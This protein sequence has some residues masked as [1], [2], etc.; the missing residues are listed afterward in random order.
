M[1]HVNG[2]DVKHLFHGSFWR[3]SI[4]NVLSVIIFV[5]TFLFAFGK[6]AER[7][8]RMSEW[9]SQANNRIERMDTNGTNF[10][11]TN[12]ALEQQIISSHENRI[13]KMEELFGR[14]NVMGEKIDRL[15]E[16]MKVI[17]QSRDK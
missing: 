8:D 15:S 4:G 7:F 9:Q 11:H 1:I 17:R 12:L 10:S 13:V 3:I 6:L 16:D 5:A 2:P 14:I